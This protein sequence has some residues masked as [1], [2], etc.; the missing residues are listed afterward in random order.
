MITNDTPCWWHGCWQRAGHFL[1]TRDGWHADERATPLQGMTAA[2][3]GCYAPRRHR[4]TGGICYLYQC[5]GFKESRHALNY[6]SDE[7]P[8]GQFLRHY[9]KGREVTCL[10]WWDRAQGDTRGACNSCFLVKGEH[11]SAEMLEWFPKMFPIQAENIGR[12]CPASETSPYSRVEPFKL[13]EVFAT[14]TTVYE[15]RCPKCDKVV[16]HTRYPSTT[17]IR[18]SPHRAPELVGG[19][20]YCPGSDDHVKWVDT[21]RKE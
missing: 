3:D 2:L 6:T 15:L 16:H 13:V 17:M 4:R 9:F 12:G 21:G 1:F 8:M 10:T 5:G 20:D 18:M 14:P 11:T 7:L 19:A